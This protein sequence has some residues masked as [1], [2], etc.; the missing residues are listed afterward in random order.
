MRKTALIILVLSFIL[1]N[2]ANA[3]AHNDRENITMNKQN[4]KVEKATFAGGMFLV[5]GTSI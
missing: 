4:K 2:F 3:N 1:G 5:H